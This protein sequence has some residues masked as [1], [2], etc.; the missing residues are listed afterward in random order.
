MYLKSTC[1]HVL[2]AVL[3]YFQ[4][5]HTPKVEANMNELTEFNNMELAFTKGKVWSEVK[6]AVESPQET[7]MMLAPDGFRNIWTIFERDADLMVRTYR[8]LEDVS[9]TLSTP[10]HYAAIIWIGPTKEQNEGEAEWLK[11]VASL[12]KHIKA[13]SRIVGVS[14]PRGE[15]NWKETRRT[16][17]EAMRLLK[18]SVQIAADNVISKIPQDLVLVFDEPFAALAASSRSRNNDVYHIEAVNDIIV[19]FRTNCPPSLS[20]PAWY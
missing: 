9:T 7:K 20:C 4:F 19:P 10:E 13:G 2:F 1:E 18:Q 6:E 14:S 11:V 12:G 8:S 5:V 16:Q 17:A 3:Q 15:E